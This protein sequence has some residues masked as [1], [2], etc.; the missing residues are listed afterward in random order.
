MKNISPRV[1]VYL[2]AAILITLG[3]S[4]A[5]KKHRDYG[6]PWLPGGYESVW[7]VE[8]EISFT[9]RDEPVRA[10]LALPAEHDGFR[11]LNENFASPGYG[12]EEQEESEFLRRGSWTRREASGTQK[13]YYRVQLYRDPEFLRSGVSPAVV[14]RS[15][16]SVVT[17]YWEDAEGLAVNAILGQAR[18][19]SVDSISLAV[20]LVQML[21]AEDNNQNINLLRSRLNDNG[22][23]II[24]LRDL[25]RSEGIATRQVRGVYLTEGR[26]FQPIVEGLEFYNDGYWHYLD[27]QNARVGVPANFLIWQRGG[28]SLLDLEGGRNS[29][30]R[31]SVLRDTRPAQQLAQVNMRSDSQVLIDF[32]IYSLPIEDQNVFK[33]LLLIPIGAFVIVI[34]RNVVGLITS[35]TFMPILIALAF[36][37]TRLVPGVILFIVVVAAG[38]G[39]RSLLS[40]L[41]LLVVPRISAVV[42]VVILLMAALSIISHHLNLPWGL[43]VTFFPMI[44]IAW[45]IERLSILWEEEGGY[46][47]LIQASGS[48]FVAILAY[49]VMN[50]SWVRHVT[51]SFPELLLVILAAILL[52]GQY[53]GYR[54]TELSRFQPFLRK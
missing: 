42:I 34:L 47:A 43:R 54:L 10:T 38:L 31:I 2:L 12:F 22:G 32:S 40:H 52:L 3:V 48:L 6:F 18:E 33:R 5:W 23:E 49:L 17:P 19:R 29:Q 44:I 53:S 35:G 21:R 27:L 45:T 39:I 1:Q 20:Q 26:R 7:T 46:A 9:A 25:L 11:I 51:Y 36:Q 14:A 37:E 4:L 24:L 13:L 41:N 28:Q 15:T 8:A 50:L 30:V 16:P